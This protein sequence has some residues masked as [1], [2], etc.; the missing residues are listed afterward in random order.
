M[1]KNLKI[2]CPGYSQHLLEDAKWMFFTD[3]ER[4]TIRSLRNQYDTVYG[5]SP[6]I[7]DD[8]SQLQLQYSLGES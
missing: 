2:P 8:F 1:C 5:K 4:K 3:H 6:L 7:F